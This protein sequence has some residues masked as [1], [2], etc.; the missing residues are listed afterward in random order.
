MNLG[1]LKC[2]TKKLQIDENT[3]RVVAVE[4]VVLHHSCACVALDLAKKSKLCCSTYEALA[5][6]HKL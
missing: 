2:S 6:R 1:N 3:R 5:L 4:W